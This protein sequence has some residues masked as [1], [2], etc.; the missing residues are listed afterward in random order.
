[1]CKTLRTVPGT[2]RMLV[3]LIWGRQ[4]TPCQE[5]P[6][7]F[8]S[9]WKIPLTSRSCVFS[10]LI[11]PSAISLYS[12]G[13]FHRTDSK[14]LLRWNEEEFIVWEQGK[15]PSPNL[16]WKKFFNL[17]ISK[18]TPICLLFELLHVIPVWVIRADNKYDVYVNF[19]KF[20]LSPLKKKPLSLFL[21][22]SLELYYLIKPSLI[23]FAVVPGVVV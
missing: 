2:Q 14:N 10:N 22:S 4:W 7:L 9:G 20:P 5:R 15:A 8:L 6:L 1:M 18:F 16:T 11:V 3:K 12:H 17:Y 23:K 13:L 19:P 21:I